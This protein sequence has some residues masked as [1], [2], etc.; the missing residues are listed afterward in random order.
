MAASPSSHH[1][2]PPLFTPPCRNCVASCDLKCNPDLAHIA[3]HARNA[4]Y[5]PN[6]FC[7][8]ILRMREPKA[9]GLIFSSGK[10]V[11]TGAKNEDDAL[12]ATKKIAKIIQKLGFA[13]VIGQFRI[14]NLIASGDCGFPIR[15][16]GIAD[17]H[18]KFSS[19][20]PELF[21]GLI[22]R[23]ES[24]RVVL[25]VFVSGKI[26]ITGECRFTVSLSRCVVV[27]VS[28]SRFSP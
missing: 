27:A 7:A 4:E 15:L 17:E 13:C 22:Y 8:V 6:R 12:L 26:V 3:T 11:V 21:P 20:E 9:T 5:N 19:Y 23:M 18:S 1:S 25:L 24:P 14:Q 10:M 16:E 28:L 2:L